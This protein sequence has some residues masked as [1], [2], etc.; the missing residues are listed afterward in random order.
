MAIC[1]A[2]CSFYSPVVSKSIF[3][4]YVSFHN[5]QGI[6]KIFERNR[7][8]LLSTIM[9]VLN[10]LHIIIF[11]L[12]RIFYHLWIWFNLFLILFWSTHEDTHLR[13]HLNISVISSLTQITNVALSGGIGAA[14]TRKCDLVR[15]N[16]IG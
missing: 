4:Y 14:I 8:L 12:R 10:C 15:F 2:I 11:H 16:L 3:L 13:V 7:L 1:M 6:T 5:V 9:T